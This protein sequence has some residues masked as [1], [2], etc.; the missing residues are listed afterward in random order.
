MEIQLPPSSAQP[1]FGVVLNS[2][3]SFPLHTLC[4]FPQTGII[5]LLNSAQATQK[6]D[7]LHDRARELSAQGL[8]ESVPHP[9]PAPHPKPR[10]AWQSQEPGR[11]QHFPS[12]TPASQRRR[13]AGKLLA[14]CIA[15][16]GRVHPA[17]NAHKQEGEVALS[18]GNIP[19]GMSFSW[20]ECHLR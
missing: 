3:P 12:L 9:K 14:L 11:S 8:W 20:S 16:S 10:K 17:Q 5:Q 15:E 18:R 1:S 4:C 19:E 7:F 13:K 6:G 2:P